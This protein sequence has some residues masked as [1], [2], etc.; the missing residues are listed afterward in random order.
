MTVPSLRPGQLIRPERR[1]AVCVGADAG[2]GM[3]EFMEVPS[4]YLDFFKVTGSKVDG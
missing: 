2:R 4:D 1:G 3:R